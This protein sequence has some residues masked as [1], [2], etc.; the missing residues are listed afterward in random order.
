MRN[1][2]KIFVGELEAKGTLGG[3]GLG[4]R[5]ISEWILG[6]EGGRV[7]IGFMWHKIVP[8]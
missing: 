4:G 3:V 7:W 2:Y 5:I 8:L 1:A 6:K